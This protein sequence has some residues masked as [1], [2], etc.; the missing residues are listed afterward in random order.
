VTFAL[1]G[2][3]AYQAF[4]AALAAAP[5]VEAAGRAADSRI[6]GGTGR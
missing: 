5:Q 4:Q 1:R 6:A 2:A 3:A